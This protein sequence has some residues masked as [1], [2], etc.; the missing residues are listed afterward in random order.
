[1]AEYLI[2]HGPLGPIIKGKFKRDTSSPGI[3]AFKSDGDKIHI[4]GL[5]SRARDWKSIVE[6]SPAVADGLTNNQVSLTSIMQANKFLAWTYFTDDEYEQYRDLYE[7]VKGRTLIAKIK[8][9][10]KVNRKRKRDADVGTFEDGI[11]VSWEPKGTRDNTPESVIIIK[12]Q[13]LTVY[14]DNDPDKIDSDMFKALKNHI[15]NDGDNE[16]GRE[17]DIVLYRY[18]IPNGFNTV[19]NEFYKERSADGKKYVDIAMEKMRKLI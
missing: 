16:Y 13:R 7:S 12:N 18:F 9:R 19:N 15:E 4:R 8:P 5:E 14:V 6:G 2:L 1:M 17:T 3:V 10:E 11:Y